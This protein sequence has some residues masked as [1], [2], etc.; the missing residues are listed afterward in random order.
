M[1]QLYYCM[2]DSLKKAIKTKPLI[3]LVVNIKFGALVRTVGADGNYV[4]SNAPS[5]YY[6]VEN[7]G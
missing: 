4:I 7:K 5:Y 6:W 2:G 1:T 3:A